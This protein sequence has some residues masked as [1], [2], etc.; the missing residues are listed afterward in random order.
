ME[1]GILGVGVLNCNSLLPHQGGKERKEIRWIW[2]RRNKTGCG[3][4][5]ILGQERGKRKGTLPPMMSQQSSLVLCLATS[6]R[7]YTLDDMVFVFLGSRCRLLHYLEG[8]D[9][10]A[11]CFG[12]MEESGSGP[13]GHCLVLAAGYGP[14]ITYPNHIFSFLLIPAHP[15]YFCLF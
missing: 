12:L 10:L 9:E 4:L 1:S 6:S 2:R 13:M 5:W 11:S 14:P 8:S 7:V 15:N 3:D